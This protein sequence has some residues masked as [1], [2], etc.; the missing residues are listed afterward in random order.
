MSG[1]RPFTSAS[2][3]D[4]TADDLRALV[5]SG[6]TNAQIAARY[7]V[8]PKAVE[9]RLNALGIQRDAATVRAAL[10]GTANRPD[11]SGHALEAASLANKPLSVEQ[12]AALWSIDLTVWE[13]QSITPNTWGI[14]AKHPETGEI[15]TKPLYQ[16]K[17]R[18]V[19]K[20]TPAL[21]QLAADLIAT[22][23]RESTR[24]RRVTP[25]RIALPSGDPCALE[26]DLFD[27][28]VGKYAWAEETGVNYDS[29]IAEQTAT[30]A[31]TDLLAQ[32][33][34]G[35]TIDEVIVPI[36]NDWYH[37]D[38]PQG[39]TNAGT[40]Q[41]R[42]T[43]YQRM[44]RI[45]H[46]IAS[47]MIE[48]CAEIAPVRVIVVPGNHDTATAFCLG[49]VLEAEFAGDARVSFDNSPRKRKY[50]DY[51]KVLL[52]YAHGHEE[53]PD[54]YARLMP[55]EE[56]ERWARTTCREFHLGHVHTGKQK[57]P[58]IV[59]DKCGVT[60]R[61]MRSLAGTD[62]WHASKG[63]LGI[64]SAEAFLWRKAGGLRS[65]MVSKP[66]D[67]LLAMGTKGV[68]MVRRADRAAR[69][70]SGR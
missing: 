69:R 36:G 27:L 60:V 40:P 35:C 20:A 25:K 26:V 49:V 53:K 32:V 54:H 24:R 46:G 8:T 57:E 56:P 10:R 42:D 4:A 23:R 59:E 13:A 55:V 11:L 62:A 48:R 39:Q 70:A 38:N 63:Y 50:H 18:F 6:H 37:V 12:I 5:T 51:G 45:G 30:A 21:E 14:G 29:D 65:H 44:F 67:E 64:R 17:V 43:R 7:H 58:L 3:R 52:G 31:A 41:D 33:P 22:M 15:L 68:S 1:G 34:P 2:W 16:T 47:W 61:W 28:H 66:V 9:R 19:R